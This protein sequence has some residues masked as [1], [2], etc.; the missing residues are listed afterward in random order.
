M[1]IKMFTSAAAVAALLALAPAHAHDHSQGAG[2]AEAT[3]SADIT[4]GDLTLSHAFTRAMPPNAP[5]A[6]GY[7]SIANAGAED[8]RL[9]AA[10][11]DRA[12][13]VQIHEMTM[14]GSVMKMRELPDG[15]PLPAGETV[16]LKP[17]GYHL[18]FMGVTD[19]F[20]EG[21]AVSVTLTFEKAGAVTLELPVTAM[22]AKAA[23]DID[24]GGHSGH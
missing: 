2:H 21:Q 9:V 6:G 14:D 8:D 4:Q 23:D 7:L 24:T 22:R 18:M 15:L 1:K 20:A 10:S 13:E 5:V 17:G 16:E 11:S 19:P 12:K 3:E